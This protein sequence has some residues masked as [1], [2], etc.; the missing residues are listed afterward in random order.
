[1]RLV[2]QFAQ[3]HRDQLGPATEAFGCSLGTGTITGG[4]VFLL[5]SNY[6]AVLDK[7]EHG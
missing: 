2:N 4:L 5:S 1:L 3:Q 7:S 6:F